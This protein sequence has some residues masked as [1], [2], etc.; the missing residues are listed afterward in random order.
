MGTHTCRK[1][2]DLTGPD[3][4]DSDRE[5]EGNVSDSHKTYTET[6]LRFQIVHPGGVGI[7]SYREW[8]Q[9]RGS[10]QE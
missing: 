6:F 5:R 3:G 8:T 1:D 2:R 9:V 4:P 10:F 7:G